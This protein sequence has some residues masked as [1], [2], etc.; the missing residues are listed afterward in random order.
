MYLYHGLPQMYVTNVLFADVCVD[1][2]MTH[3]YCYVSQKRL[4][5]TNTA[6]CHKC[7]GVGGDVRMCMR[8]KHVVASWMCVCLPRMCVSWM[9][10]SV[11]YVFRA[12]VCI[13]DE[14]L[15]V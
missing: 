4:C 10:V 6:F 9:C 14:C 12:C 13:T 5:L 11:T 2:G 7:G 8:V 3:E 1:V 15:L